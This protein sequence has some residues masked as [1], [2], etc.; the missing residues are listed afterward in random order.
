MAPIRATFLKQRNAQKK[1]AKPS[2]GTAK[3]Q[4][5]EPSQEYVA[6]DPTAIVATIAANDDDELL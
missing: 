6:I 1:T 2:E 4:R 3:R 5:V